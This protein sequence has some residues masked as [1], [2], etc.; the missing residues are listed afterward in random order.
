MS[1]PHTCTCRICGDSM[2]P[3]VA[4]PIQW[5]AGHCGKC[6]APYT[7]DLRL[8]Y[9]FA[10]PG[11][12]EADPDLTLRAYLDARLV[13]VVGWAS[14]HRHDLLSR[15]AADCRRELDRRWARNIMLS[16]WLDYL[17]DRGHTIR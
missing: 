12:V 16:K 2:G 6:G 5:A 4:A 15:L 17:Q 14:G 9:V 3:F 8:T 11:G 13:E 7:V 1:M 10:M